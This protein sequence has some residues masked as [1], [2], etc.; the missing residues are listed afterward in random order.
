MD[1]LKREDQFVELMIRGEHLI[2]G[3]GL[4]DGH[5]EGNLQ[6]RMAKYG[7]VIAQ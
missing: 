6:A 7:Q 3:L 5:L 2:D 1:A 4:V